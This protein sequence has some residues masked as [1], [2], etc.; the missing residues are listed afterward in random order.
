M[1]LTK[2]IKT[3]ATISGAFKSARCLKVF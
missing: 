1:K 2:T 3:D